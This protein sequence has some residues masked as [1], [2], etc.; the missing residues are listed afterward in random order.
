MRDA[1]DRQYEQLVK[2]SKRR[3]IEAIM[4]E[5]YDQYPDP[6]GLLTRDYDVHDRGEARRAIFGKLRRKR[7]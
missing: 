5:I 2:S 6:P 7:Q 3:D 4:K 1:I